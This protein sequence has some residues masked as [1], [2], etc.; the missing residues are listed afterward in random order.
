MGKPGAALREKDIPPV[1]ALKGRDRVAGYYRFSENILL[2]QSV[3]I[4]I[5]IFPTGV[6]PRLAYLTQLGLR[7]LRILSRK[8]YG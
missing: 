8:R 3:T 6:L 2:F 5:G 1:Y 7:L 4:G